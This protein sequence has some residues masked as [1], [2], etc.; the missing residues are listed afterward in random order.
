M[1]GINRLECQSFMSSSPCF[2]YFGEIVQYMRVRYSGAI[3]RFV[4]FF[5]FFT[6]AGIFLFNIYSGKM[7]FS[8]W[9]VVS[10]QANLVED[11]HLQRRL[12]DDLGASI[13]VFE[14][15]KFDDCVNDDSIFI[16]INGSDF[17]NSR[18]IQERDMLEVFDDRAFEIIEMG[19]EKEEITALSFTVSAEVDGALRRYIYLSYIP[20]LPTDIRDKYFS[21]AVAEEIYQSVMRANDVVVSDVPVSLAEEY[22]DLDFLEKARASG[23]KSNHS[24]IFANLTEYIRLSYQNNPINLCLRDAYIIYLRSNTGDVSSNFN[25]M[26]KTKLPKVADIYN[27]WFRMGL[28]E[29]IC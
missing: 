17:T 28:I 26:V 16:R 27:N 4:L 24:Y 13:R 2:K 10:D 8:D 25:K 7:T 3:M 18:S 23:H 11:I 29:R 22:L 1:M 15:E 5:S 9:C 12:Y 6:F 21:A 14:V 20:S 19:D